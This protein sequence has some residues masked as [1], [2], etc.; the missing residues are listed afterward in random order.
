M[1]TQARIWVLFAIALIAYF[2]AAPPSAGWRSTLFVFLAMAFLMAWSI[3]RR[4]HLGR[5]W[6]RQQ[7]AERGLA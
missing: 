4:L 5:K 6:K 3:A 7:L 2:I 1:R